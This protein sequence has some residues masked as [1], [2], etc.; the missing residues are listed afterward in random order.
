MKKKTVKFTEAKAYLAAQKVVKYAEKIAKE[1]D[2]LY[3]I[4]ISF[5]DRKTALLQTITRYR[6]EK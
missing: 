3:K 2:Q 6:K 5:C 1:T 4:D